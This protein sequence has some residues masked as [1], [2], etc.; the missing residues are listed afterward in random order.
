MFTE[1]YIQDNIILYLKND[2]CLSELL[3]A[4]DG[5]PVEDGLPE[6]RMLTHDQLDQLATEVLR[7][8]GWLC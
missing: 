5:H 4:Y 7:S 1:V 2:T 6:G 8:L 3:S